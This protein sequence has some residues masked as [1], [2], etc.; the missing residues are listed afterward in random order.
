[1]RTTMTL[2]ICA[3][4]AGCGITKTVPGPTEHVLVACP[5]VVPDVSCPERKQPEGAIM[6]E[7][8]NGK[9]WMNV[10]HEA[11]VDAWLEDRKPRGECAESVR[12]MKSEIAECLERL[13]GEE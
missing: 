11:L 1:M 3:L 5:P 13:R 9:P 8:Q 10:P 6:W 2:L 7:D 12:V 4:V